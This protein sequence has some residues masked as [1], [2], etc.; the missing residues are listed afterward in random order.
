MSRTM[1]SMRG[2]GSGSVQSETTFLA[3][4]DIAKLLGLLL[5]CS[6][7]SLEDD[8]LI[9]PALMGP[10][11]LYLCKLVPIVSSFNSH[12]FLQKLGRFL[13]ICIQKTE[14]QVPHRKK[15]K[16]LFAHFCTFCTGYTERFYERHKAIL[17][18]TWLKFRQILLSSDLHERKSRIQ[19]EVLQ[20]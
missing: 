6:E 15:K 3:P 13:M 1:F 7:M 2:Q 9:T 18:V 17:S 14:I 10:L 4:E 11:T 5:P 12:W 20:G 19:P 8:A 16:N